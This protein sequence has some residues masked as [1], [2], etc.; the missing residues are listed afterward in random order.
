MLYRSK[1]DVRIE[2]HVNLIGVA[3]YIYIFCVSLLSLCCFAVTFKL[4]VYYC[5]SFFY[6]TNRTRIEQKGKKGRAQANGKKCEPS[7]LKTKKKRL[8]S[9]S[10]IS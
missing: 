10:E 7:E 8:V 9:V 3:F 5:F 2:K 4:P 6:R 1:C